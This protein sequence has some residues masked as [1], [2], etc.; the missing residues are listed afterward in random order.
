V[1]N[2]TNAVYNLSHSLRRALA[3]KGVE[4]NLL[5]RTNMAGRQLAPPGEEYEQD[6]EPA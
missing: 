5:M 6:N 4:R 1:I 3:L 2:Q